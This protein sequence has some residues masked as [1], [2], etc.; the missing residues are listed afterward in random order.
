MWTEIEQTLTKTEQIWTEIEQ[1]L[2]KTGQ[3]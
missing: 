1:I 3:F 2:T